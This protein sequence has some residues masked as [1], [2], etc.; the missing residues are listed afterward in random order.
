MTEPDDQRADQEFQAPL[1]QVFEAV[2]AKDA[3]RAEKAMRE[4]IRLAMHNMGI[5][6]QRRKA[7]QSAPRQFV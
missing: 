3:G 2:A 6:Q 7:R 5:L 1:P 4:L